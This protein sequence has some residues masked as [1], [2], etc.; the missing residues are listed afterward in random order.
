MKVAT[1]SH[2]IGK[3]KALFKPFSFNA[4]ICTHDDGR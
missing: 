4:A 3:I 1:L 2:R